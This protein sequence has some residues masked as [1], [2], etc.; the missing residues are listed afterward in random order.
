MTKRDSVWSRVVRAA[1]RLSETLTRPDGADSPIDVA[2]SL[3][4]EPDQ[5]GIGRAEEE[6]S[7]VVA[8][9]LAALGLP[10]RPEVTV[11]ADAGMT[12]PYRLR[13]NGRRARC[14]VRDLPK[15]ADS[16]ELPAHA[17]TICAAAIV[18]RPSV[19]LDAAY[20]GQLGGGDLLAAAL[21][22]VLDQGVSLADGDAVRAVVEASADALHPA[23][24]AEALIAALQPTTVD[25]R[26]ARE[27][28]RYVTT[29]QPADKELF[30][31]LRKKFYFEQGVLGPGFRFVVD[32]AVPERRFA[33][34]I[35]ALTLPSRPL[36]T[37]RPLDEVHDELHTVLQRHASRLVSL[38]GLTEVLEPLRWALP[39]TIRDVEKR[40]S[41]RWL[42]A[43]ARALVA[44]GISVRHPAT[45]LD[46]LLDLDPT[47]APPGS[48]R[49]SEGPVPVA[50]VRSPAR[51]PAP[52][53]AVALLRRRW[54]E[55]HC[56]IVPQE[57]TL[58]VHQLSPEALSAAP[59]EGA[60]DQI[61]DEIRPEVA[62]HPHAPLVVPSLPVRSWLL[63]EV[64][65]EFPDLRVLAVQEIPPHLRLVPVG[66]ETPQ[67]AGPRR[68][69]GVW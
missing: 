2:M 22:E 52:R 47:A 36:R 29:A 56:R 46:W 60:A 20:A 4:V 35:N 55:E 37:D 16:A 18:R 69:A 66:P 9:N 13:I 54:L 44:E 40:Y 27:T 50:A 49:L 10:G 41:G 33:I 59:S 67:T 11:T 19:L 14:A 39:D 68:V 6:V 25:L 23:E 65:S 62:L 3:A 32:P 51:L 43:V 53:D 1:D 63:G 15:P 42:A 61:A 58:A 28:L 24:L 12:E 21:P 17:A 64:R 5:P 7:A 8:S 57:I 48:V 30:P 38:T 26:L 31:S 45:L 34:R